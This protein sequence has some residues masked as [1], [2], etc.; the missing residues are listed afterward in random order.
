MSGG[1][2]GVDVIFPSTRPL[3]APLC[4]P[5]PALILPA[6]LSPEGL[7]GARLLP[8]RPAPAACPSRLLRQLFASR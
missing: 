4:T 8:L 3:Y 6:C 7:L 1:V 2:E 5:P